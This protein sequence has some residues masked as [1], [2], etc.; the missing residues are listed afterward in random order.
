[1]IFV[2]VCIPRM[3]V[4]ISRETGTKIFGSIQREANEQVVQLCGSSNFQGV[5]KRF[6]WIQ[7]R[8]KQLPKTR[9]VL[10]KNLERNEDLFRN[11]SVTADQAR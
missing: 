2:Y 7:V 1:M 9:F 5:Q 8:K 6:Q 4:C 11:L 10:S 3:Y